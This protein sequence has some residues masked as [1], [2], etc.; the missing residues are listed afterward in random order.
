MVTDTHLP[1]LPRSNTGLIQTLERGV[2]EKLLSRAIVPPV[3]VTFLRKPLQNPSK[4]AQMELKDYPRRCS[5]GG[6]MNPT[7]TE[8]LFD[9]KRGRNGNRE[10][11]PT[12]VTQRR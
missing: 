1:A 6:V 11:M 9:R 7:D 8:P 2:E 10:T 3:E 5:E 12:N 4:F